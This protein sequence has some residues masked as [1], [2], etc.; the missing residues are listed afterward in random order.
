MDRVTH[1]ASRARWTN[2]VSGFVPLPWI[3][4]R[5]SPHAGG[6]GHPNLLIPMG[7]GLSRLESIDG[8]PALATRVPCFDPKGKAGL[9]PSAKTCFTLRGEAGHRGSGWRVTD[10]PSYYGRLG[11]FDNLLYIF[12]KRAFHGSASPQ[13]WYDRHGILLPQRRIVEGFRGR[14]ILIHEGNK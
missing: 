6:E 5:F 13:I 11:R 3:M 12:L 9:A 8:C 2:P 1:G 14:H 10:C 7:T 4:P